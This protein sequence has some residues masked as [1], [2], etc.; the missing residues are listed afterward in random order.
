MRPPRSRS[1]K[2]GRLYL[3]G[4]VVNAERMPLI[5]ITV[6]HMKHQIMQMLS[7]VLMSELIEGQLDAAIKA[8]DF[9]GEV[10]KVAHDALRES[11]KQYF[12]SWNSP[13]CKIIEQAVAAAINESLEAY[14]KEQ[15]KK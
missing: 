9:E 5:T 12:T 14:A 13:G 15:Q 11:V 8:F 3:K 2:G 4:K 10:K 6:D 1:S 7:P